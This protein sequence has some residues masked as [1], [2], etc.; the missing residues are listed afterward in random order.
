MEVLCC[1]AVGVFDFLLSQSFLVA[2]VS[3][4][5]IFSA[6]APAPIMQADLKMWVFEISL[7]V[8]RLHPKFEGEKVINLWVQAIKI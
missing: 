6:S 5:T 1:G 2:N 8:R 4:V 3:A 7:S